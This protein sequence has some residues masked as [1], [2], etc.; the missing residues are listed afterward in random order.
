MDDSRHTACISIRDAESLISLFL[1]MFEWLD[2]HGVDY[3][4]V[5]GLGVLVQAYNFGAE[6]FRATVDADVMF[7]AAFTNV[8][9]AR[10]YLDVYASDSDYSRVVYD[11]VFGEDAFNELSTEAQALVNASFIGAELDIDGISTPDFD[12]VRTL[13]GIDLADIEREPVEILGHTVK[14]ATAAQLLVMKEHT[15]EMLHADFG[16]TSRPQDFIDAMRLRVIIDSLRGA[17]A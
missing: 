1:P 3:C 12:V 9:F 17:R 14:V 7:D 16:T 8:D 4:L 11:A 2:E 13:N 5:G 10:A 15:I 6:D